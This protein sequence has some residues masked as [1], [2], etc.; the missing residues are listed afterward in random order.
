L[1]NYLEGD[2]LN[3]LNNVNLALNYSHMDGPARWMKELLEQHKNLPP[4][5]W[6]GVRDIDKKMDLPEINMNKDDLR[7]QDTGPMDGEIK[8]KDKQ[9]MSE[10]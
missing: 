4:D 8:E 3:A 7:D 9:S 5:N 2:W 6:I 1:A 10:D